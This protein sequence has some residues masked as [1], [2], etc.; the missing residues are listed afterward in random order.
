MHLSTFL[1]KDTKANDVL[2]YFIA[3][4]S[5][6]MPSCPHLSVVKDLFFSP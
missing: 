1:G 3:F 4:L 2:C 6:F 5:V